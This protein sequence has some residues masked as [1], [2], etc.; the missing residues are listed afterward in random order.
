MDNRT[1]KAY[2]DAADA[3]ADLAAPPSSGASD[4]PSEVSARESIFPDSAQQAEALQAAAE[5]TGDV[6]QAAWAACPRARLRR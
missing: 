3:S 1:I 4:E 2:N 5:P 6:Q